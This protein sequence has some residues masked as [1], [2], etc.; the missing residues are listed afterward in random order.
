MFDIGGKILHRNSNINYHRES[1]FNIWMN[2]CGL[3]VWT[4]P[5]PWGR[6]TKGSDVFVND[7]I[8][9]VHIS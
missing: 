5:S 9:R 8:S 4:K 3:A 7:N 6:N 1:F 2:R